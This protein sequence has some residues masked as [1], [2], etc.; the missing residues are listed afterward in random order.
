M[1]GHPSLRHFRRGI[2]LVSQWTGNEYKNMEKVFLGALNGATDSDVL[3][4]VRGIMDFVYYAHF[5]THTTAS[6]AKLEAAWKLFHAH[7]HV[8][9]TKEIHEH[10]NIPKIHSMQHYVAMIR[11]LGTADGYNTELSERLHI[12]CAKLG[13]AASSKREYINQMTRWLMR[14]EAIH[15]FA[16]YL[17]WAIPGYLVEV[18]AAMPEPNAADGES[19]ETEEE[20]EEEEDADDVTA[21]SQ[22]GSIY[23]IAKKAPF[24]ASLSLLWRATTVHSISLLV[25]KTFDALNPCFPAAFTTSPP[26]SPFTNVLSFKS[27][28][29]QV[30]G[31]VTNDPIRATRPVPSRGLKKA[32]PSHF[33]TVLA[34]KEKP[35]RLG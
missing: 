21:E 11:S 15:R 10:F 3:R 14:R 9:I 29:V 4:A 19:A 35:T 22:L 24:P 31:S 12:D 13:Y 27:H 26:H 25:L 17:Q 2:S 5:E 1:T 20:E 6:L 16:S 7:K 30:S 18:A 34:R 33:D 32:A 8:F 23:T 28:P